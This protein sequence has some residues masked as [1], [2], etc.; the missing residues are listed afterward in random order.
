MESVV[1]V[2]KALFSTADAII[3]H[4]E[5]T[6]K[7]LIQIFEFKF[8]LLPRSLLIPALLDTVT[9]RFNIGGT[10]QIDLI[11]CDIDIGSIR[12]LHFLQY[13]FIQM[14]PLAKWSEGTPFF[15]TGR[16][17]LVGVVLV[18]GDN[19]IF[20]CQLRD[21]ITNIQGICTDIHIDVL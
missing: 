4:P 2:S 13:A 3:V 14:L 21:I 6:S 10:T 9:E 8:T 15:R 1:T 18:V 7:C 11:T 20:V 19:F 16:A 5:F 17:S 12:S